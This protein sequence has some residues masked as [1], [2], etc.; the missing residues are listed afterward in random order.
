MSCVSRALGLALIS[1]FNVNQR[2][3]TMHRLLCGLLENSFLSSL[4]LERARR[5]TLAWAYLGEC[6]A[7]ERVQILYGQVARDV[8][9]AVTACGCTFVLTVLRKSSKERIFWRLRLCHTVFPVPKA[10]RIR[11][12]QSAFCAVQSDFCG[13]PSVR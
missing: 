5:N 11:E 12:Y 7:Y 13:M 6:S 10:R 4:L 3:C 1:P 8:R 2:Q 9:T